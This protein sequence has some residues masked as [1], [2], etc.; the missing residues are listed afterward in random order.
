[1]RTCA[2]SRDDIVDR[3]AP[4][5]SPL[6]GSTSRSTASTAS[7]RQI[8]RSVLAGSPIALTLQDARN[9]RY[10]QVVKQGDALLNN[11]S[12]VSRAISTTT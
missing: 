9:A 4:A 7:S 11:L 6:A 12:R 10:E 1:M 2:W 5:S 3:A 8:A